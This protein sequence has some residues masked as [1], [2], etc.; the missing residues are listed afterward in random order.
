MSKLHSKQV[1]VAP[2]H[3]RYIKLG[4]GGAWEAAS[5]DGDRIDWG[6]KA[7]PLKLAA[8]AD[9]EG[10]KQSYSEAGLLPSTA[11]GYLRELKDFY[12]LGSDCL[13]ITFARGHLWWGFA[14]P[15]V[16]TN[17]GDTLAEGACYR[18]VIGGWRNIDVMGRELTIDGLSSKLTQL[19]GYRRTIC[20]VSASEYLLRRINAEEE[21]VVATARTARLALIEASQA[22]IHQLHWDDFETFVDLIFSR[23]GWRR[24]SR[25][26]GRM[27]DIDL[28]LE[29]P[30]TGERT[31]VQVKSAAD[32]GVLNACVAAFEANKSASRFFFVCHS[33]RSALSVVAS[34][35][36]PVDLWTIERLAAAAVDQ[37]LTDWLIER[38][39]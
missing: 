31:S 17:T 36:G 10:T 28:L 16:I 25:L 34:G 39:D 33:P 29:Q 6:N 38:A 20:N 5:L 14:E 22:L 37:G 23:A 3:V 32:Q 27:K 1:A 35:E 7:D 19:A 30:L 9:W 11:T 24:V 2:A 13:W 12:N 8:A 4:P 15:D 18:S 21:P 26:G